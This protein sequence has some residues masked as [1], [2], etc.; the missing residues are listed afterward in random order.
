MTQVGSCN[1]DRLIHQGQKRNYLVVWALEEELLPMWELCLAS[2]TKKLPHKSSQNVLTPK[3]IYVHR[4]SLN[5]PNTLLTYCKKTLGNKKEDNNLISHK[6]PDLGTKV[7]HSDKPIWGGQ[8]GSWVW[9]ILKSSP[10]IGVVG[11]LLN[12]NTLLLCFFY[13]FCVC[14]FPPQNI[15]KTWINFQLL[16]P[17]T[18]AL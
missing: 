9:E 2:N 14:N 17:Q 11:L 5:K 3:N 4:Y 10:L 16:L 15:S 6:S 8:Y 18:H 12:L 7:H 1:T 13:L